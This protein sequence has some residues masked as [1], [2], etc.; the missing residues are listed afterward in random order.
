MT[1]VAVGGGGKR[2]FT[3]LSLEDTRTLNYTVSGYNGATIDTAYRPT[4][5]HVTSSINRFSI[6]LALKLSDK[7]AIKLCL[8]IPALL[9]HVATLP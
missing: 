6:L 7:F 3:L 1:A 5:L 4:L 2:N 9:N 8:D